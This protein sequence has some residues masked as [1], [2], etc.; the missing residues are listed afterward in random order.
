MIN[1]KP[2]VTRAA[3]CQYLAVLC[4]VLAPASQAFAGGK[5][6]VR[7]MT[8]NQYLGAD[9]A[10]LVGAPDPA[11]FNMAMISV[12]QQIGASDY[13]QRVQ[14][15]A[16]TIEPG[17]AAYSCLVQIDNK[18][19]GCLYEASKPGRPYPWI[20]FARFDFDWLQSDESDEE[21]PQRGGSAEWGRMTIVLYK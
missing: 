1:R 12:L 15:L 9:L 21:Q 17:Y 19:L 4:L 16:K 14:K 11:A 3:V 13:A 8:Q 6:G 10:P 20:A 7:V 2:A 18:T 5:H